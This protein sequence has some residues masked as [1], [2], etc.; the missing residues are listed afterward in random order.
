MSNVKPSTGRRSVVSQTQVRRA[1][2]GATGAGL[3]VKRVTVSRDGTITIDSEP[4]ATTD[5]SKPLPG[6]E[7]I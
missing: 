1:I 2:Q 7:D 6:W 4:A 5:N 3:K